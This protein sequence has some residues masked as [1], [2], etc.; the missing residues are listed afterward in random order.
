M[1]L[2]IGN[3]YLDYDQVVL[4]CHAD[5]SLNILE[6]P[7][8]KEKEILNKFTYVSNRAFCIQMKTYALKKK[9]LV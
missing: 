3:E 9:S 7:T 1:R 5:Q 8:E 2:S 6:D 4:A